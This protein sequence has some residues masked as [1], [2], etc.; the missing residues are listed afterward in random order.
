LLSGVDSRGGQYILYYRGGSATVATKTAISVRLDTELLERAKNAV[1]W[2]GRGLT[3][4][5]ILEQSLKQAVAALEREHHE[6]EP[7]PPRTDELP[8]SP[9]PRRRKT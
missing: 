9:R 4:S 7:F 6:G 2:T 1:F 5:R 3:I 8:Y